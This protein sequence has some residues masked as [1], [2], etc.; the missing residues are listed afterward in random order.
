MIVAKWQ[1][2]LIWKCIEVVWLKFSCIKKLHINWWLL[3]FY[4]NQA[5]DVNTVKKMNNVLQ[6]FQ[7]VW[8]VIFMSIACR[9]FYICSW[10]CIA[11]GNEYMEKY[12]PI[13]LFLHY[14]FFFL[15][16]SDLIS[17]K[18]NWRHYFWSV[19]HILIGLFI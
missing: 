4:G 13:M 17:A 15:L 14:L 19:S 9:K 6:Q 16:C 18:I 8:E 12:C 5:V 1:S 3:N 2:H 7:C 11:N 10:K